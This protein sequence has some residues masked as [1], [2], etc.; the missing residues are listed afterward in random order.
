MYLKFMVQFC[1]RYFA[2]HN[3]RRRIFKGASLLS[4]HLS[5]GFVS[6]CGSV[7]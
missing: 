2:R 3:L 1:V 7:I 4:E 6:V 5:C